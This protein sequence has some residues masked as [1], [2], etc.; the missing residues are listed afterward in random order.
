MNS[1]DVIP[2]SPRIKSKK[3]RT[4]T[5]YS[6]TARQK[7]KR[8][9]IVSLRQKNRQQVTTNNIEAA[10]EEP[11][12]EQNDRLSNSPVCNVNIYA[13][14][15]GLSAEETNNASTV[16]SNFD[17]LSQPKLIEQCNQCDLKRPQPIHA[18]QANLKSRGLISLKALLSSSQ[19]VNSTQSDSS[20]QEYEA[21]SPRAHILSR[22][23]AENV[24]NEVLMENIQLSEWPLPNDFLSITATNDQPFCSQQQT[25]RNSES[26]V[27]NQN[28]RLSIDEQI[29]AN[30]TKTSSLV[31][32]SI[33][34]DFDMCDKS[35]DVEIAQTP[36][37]VL[38]RRQNRKTY[39]RKQV[40]SFKTLLFEDQND[41]KSADQTDL[42]RKKDD[43]DI[44][45]TQGGE[46]IDVEI[47]LNA[48]RRIVENLTRLST[49]F[50]QS[51]SFVLD[52]NT[53]LSQHAVTLNEE[54]REFSLES[55]D[56][57]CVKL[58]NDIEEIGTANDDALRQKNS[59][60]VRLFEEDDD[61]FANITT[62]KAEILAKRAITK[63]STPLSSQKG[64]FEESTMHSTPST[65][66]QTVSIEHR[67]PKRLRFSLEVENQTECPAFRP[68]TSKM[69]GFSKADG[70]TIQM[71]ANQMKRTAAIFADIDDKYKEIDPVLEQ[72]PLSK[73]KKR[74]AEVS[75]NESAHSSRVQTEEIET[76][77]NEK[78]NFVGGFQTAGGKTA[79]NAI[80]SSIFGEDLSDLGT[81]L[82]VQAF[83]P[84]NVP[85]MRGFA[86]ARG[87]ECKIATK[88]IERYAQTFKELEKD[89][90][91]GFEIDESNVVC[92]APKLNISSSPLPS[93]PANGFASAGGAHWTISAKNM[94]KYALTLKE[95]DK[96][97]RD[98][99][100]FDQE[101]AVCKTPMNKLNHRPKAFATSTPNPNAMSTFKDYP[102]I[103]PIVHQTAKRNE[104]D[105]LLDDMA[106]M[107]DTSTQQFVTET[108]RRTDK[109]ANLNDTIADDFQLLNDSVTENQLDGMRVP[110]EIQHE[111]ERLLSAQQTESLKKP[112][113]IRPEIGWLLV[114]KIL[115]SKKL[116][117][118]DP[119]K[120]FKRDELE[121]FGVQPNVIEISVENALQFKFDMW[122]FYAEEV[123]RSNIEGIYMQDDMCLILDRSARVGIKELTSAFLQCPSVDP[124]L[125]S[126][127]WIQNCLKWIFVKLASYERN[128][129]YWSL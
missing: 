64:R 6:D 38:V 8:R 75:M 34:D 110:I 98:G 39:T 60:S 107:F 102:P 55:D 65:S 47:D 44:E 73:K 21:E 93:G 124:K 67:I 14:I 61:I 91:N 82:S 113:P 76:I 16:L 105:H 84:S 28:L 118:L 74:S 46:N 114:Q 27:S 2:P 25:N 52:F 108:T 85:A 63:A 58:F 50:T 66:K 129:F 40:A 70:G 94:E 128:N 19:D 92:K 43:C 78:R 89:V 77:P 10:A 5:K 87:A 80:A 71:S 24:A 101:S 127:H 120:K 23:Y 100:E 126:D 22:S 79:T 116:H 30:V 72:M 96:D 90:H 48:S 4:R 69:Q 121:K 109:S 106:D 31:V 7:K 95:V 111:R 9:S 41:E 42:E 54:F 33:L 37:F 17:I 62:P 49:F 36:P 125:V 26:I 97:V 103:T 56:S 119:P 83:K 57:D 53:N 122:K 99:F 86:T 123:C 32:Q 11:N 12:A 51:Q 88:N 15:D 112:H 13:G 3:S 45:C 117:E 35:N 104:F 59:P 1:D 29:T 18:S 68:S 81:Q 115:S 20:A